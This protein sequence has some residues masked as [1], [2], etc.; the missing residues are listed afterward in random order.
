[1]HGTPA[2]HE[3]QIV[4]LV[5]R[6]TDPPAAANLPL[7][8][9]ADHLRRKSSAWSSDPRTARGTLGSCDGAYA[10]HFLALVASQPT[11]LGAPFA[12][13]A[14]VNARV[15]RRDSGAPATTNLWPHCSVTM[16]P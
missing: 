12:S 1:V 11:T 13:G 8:V 16:Q 15:W 10:L 7:A 9:R 6:S 4:A 14:I 5:D 3:G 2:K